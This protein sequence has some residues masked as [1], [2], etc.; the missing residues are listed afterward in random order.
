M[1]ESL[2]LACL[3]LGLDD[4]NCFA[5]GLI[6]CSHYSF[7]ARLNSQ[8]ASERYQRAFQ[9]IGR[10]IEKQAGQFGKLWIGEQC[11]LV[12]RNGR[13]VDQALKKEVDGDLQDI[14]QLN[15]AGRTYAT[16]AGF[17]FLDLLWRDIATACEFFLC[18]TKDL[19]TA[20]QSL[21]KQNVNLGWTAWW[22]AV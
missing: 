21:P 15:E 17:I 11:E 5:S 22:N 18:Q 13:M 9:F 8:R 3:Q 16:C 14:G 6:V 1:G 2:H 19:A 20:A 4:A 10:N 12:F 7:D